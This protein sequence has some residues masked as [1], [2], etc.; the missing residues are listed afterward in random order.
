MRKMEKT[1]GGK[2]YILETFDSF[3]E[4]LRV[5]NSRKCKPEVHEEARKEHDPRFMGAESYEEAVSLLK[6]GYTKDIEKIN[7][8]VKDL[9]KTGT[10]T[11][12]SFRN[13]IVGYAPIVPNAIIGIPQS[14]VNNV[15][16][17]KKSKVITILVDMAVSG[18]TKANEVFE[19]GIKVVQ[20]LIQL[21]QSGFRV[22]LEY[23]KCFNDYYNQHLAVSTVIKSENQ[24]LDIKRIMFPL[25]N[26]AMQRYISWDWYDRLPDVM[27]DNSKGRSLSVLSESEKKRITDQL[28]NGKENKYIIIYGDDL[29][30]TF[31]S[32]K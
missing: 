5:C 29:E 26:V 9:Q 12:T 27:W 13:D 28:V 2:R 21:E 22:R 10:T 3:D 4:I 20:K 24:P 25:T 14:M 1:V 30:K 15:R 17:P 11:K 16:V 8:V 6:H 32:V 23:L 31:Q 18:G 7:K 19:Y